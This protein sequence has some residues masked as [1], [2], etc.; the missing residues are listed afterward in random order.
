MWEVLRK[1]D[2]RLL[3]AGQAISAVGDWVRITALP[4]YAYELTDSATITGALF[5]T[6]LLPGLFLGSVA[7]VFVDRWNRKSTLIICDVLRAALVPLFLLA[8]APDSIWILF[9]VA[10]LSSLVAQFFVPARFSLI[11]VLVGKSEL[12]AAN[13]LDA[14]SDNL[15]RIVGPLLGG[16][17]LGLV[18]LYGVVLV[19]AASFLASALVL[20]FM[21]VPAT[22]AA[23]AESAPPGE[24]RP[25]AAGW[26]T[27]WLQGL[28]LLSRNRRLLWL[29]VVQG[30]ST[31]G[32]SILTVLLV[33]FVQDGLGVG[34]TKFGWL[35]TARGLGGIIG[36]LVIGQVTCTDTR[37]VR[38]L[39]GGLLSLGL[40]FLV[41]VNV[42]SFWLT[43]VLLTIVGLPA[44]AWLV[45]AQTLMQTSV[46]DKYRGR[47]FGAY[48]TVV[49]LTMLIGMGLGSTLADLIGATV[50]LNVAVGLYLLAALATLPLL[51]SPAAVEGE[52]AEA[53]DTP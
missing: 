5:V 51:H 18:G 21:R 45:G 48:T 42:P 53:L 17:M 28:R 36:G 50:M 39:G 22:E 12:A 49:S 26:A 15:A 4:F 31:L 2:F 9:V 34:A 33:V 16:T 1:R 20:S 44:M 7:G 19:D 29:F 47:V 8:S 40:I 38:L 10:L 43:L 35:L 46:S 14:L 52:V 23:A 37:A 11:P 32:D 24:P 6:Q 25:R 41:I 3:L 30:V 27:E 13:S